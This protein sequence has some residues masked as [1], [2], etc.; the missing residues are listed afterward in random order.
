PGN[1]PGTSYMRSMRSTT[2][3]HPQAAK[4]MG[5]VQ[6][7]RAYCKKLCSVCVPVSNKKGYLLGGKHSC[8]RGYSSVVEHLTADQEVLGPNPGAPSESIAN[9]VCH[10]THKEYAKCHLRCFSRE[11]IRFG[12]SIVCHNCST[13][14]QINP[15][16]FDQQGWSCFFPYCSSQDGGAV[17][18]A[19]LKVVYLPQLRYF[20]SPNG[21]VGSNPTSDM[22]F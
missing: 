22:D 11:A 12:F 17:Y 21:G 4:P 3:L 19:R 8:Y 5:V 10:S 9:W 14:T 18:G 1:D 13:R 7:E 16:A 15:R 2:E 20:W 6:R